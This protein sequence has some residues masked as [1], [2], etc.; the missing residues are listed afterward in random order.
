VEIRIQKAREAFTR[1][2]KIW[3]A[4]YINKDTKIKLFNVQYM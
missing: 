2:R 1:L 4:H 3:L